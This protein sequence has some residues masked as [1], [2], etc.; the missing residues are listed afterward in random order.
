MFLLFVAFS[1]G[2][3]AAVCRVTKTIDTND[4]QCDNDCSLREAVAS[5]SCDTVIFPG[6]TFHT[7]ATITLIGGEIK[8]NHP[9]LI[10]GTGADRLTISGNNASRIF[11]VNATASIS[12]FTLTG[13]NGGGTEAGC[14]GGIFASSGSSLILDGVHV[15]GNIATAP[16]FDGGGVHLLSGSHTIKNSTFSA[17]TGG[18]GSAIRIQG[19]S[20]TLVNSTIANNPS[21]LHFGALSIFA[22]TASVRNC[23]F[24][25]NTPGS[26]ILL[27]TFADLTFG[28]SIIDTIAN[29][30]PSLGF[31]SSVGNNL[32]TER[33]FFGTNVGYH[34]SDIFDANAPILPLQNTGGT[35]P[36]MELPSSSPAIDA[37]NNQLALDLPI[38]FDQRGLRRIFDGNSDG[39]ARIDIGAVET[40]QSQPPQGALV[41]GRILGTDGR[42]V[43]NA[44]VSVINEELDFMKTGFTNPFGHYLFHTYA[45]CYCTITVKA[46]HGTFSPVIVMVYPNQENINIFAH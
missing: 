35:T 30:G 40:G 13:G 17:N 45:G 34:P 1:S 4:G 46:K 19:G 21:G 15:T 26:S 10:I 11:Y 42:P 38:T 25:G 24:R 36:T 12:G 3:S 32:I 31:G 29:D 8:I 5:L 44:I 6:Q 23:T 37:G 33:S 16:C 7:G 39:D 27:E 14:G 18:F 9:I 20:L 43:R 2:V 41:K 22:A 28:N